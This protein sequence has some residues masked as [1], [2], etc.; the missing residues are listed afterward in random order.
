MNPS[1]Q[2]NTPGKAPCKCCGGQAASYGTVDFHK[3]CESWRTVLEPSGI[4]IQY[5]RCPDCGFIF[6]TAFDQFTMEDFRRQIYN[7][8]YLLVDPEY[9]GERPRGNAELV[10][11][12]F[13]YLK[14]RRLL[15]YGCGTGLLVEALRATGLFQEVD[16]YDPF[17]PGH[18]ARPSHRYE[19]IVCFEVL[20]HSTD[21]AR[22]L[23]EI[24]DLLT[25]NGL[26]LFSTLLQPADIEGQGL[27]WWYVLPRNGHVSLFS[28]ASLLKL[29]EPFGFGLG[30]YDENVH[31]LVK[32]VPEFAKHLIRIKR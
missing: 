19:C 7:S 28:R 32:G 12:F 26:I 16:G 4:P 17:V 5:L 23:G 3:S 13:P 14:P 2:A 8:D 15:D 22:T 21:P 18:D 27:N 29:A 31:L 20:E 11:K 10:V 30:S 25:E 24:N 1:V 6:T 9:E